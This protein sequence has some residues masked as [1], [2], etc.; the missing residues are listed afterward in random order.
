MTLYAR[1]EEVAVRDFEMLRLIS[2][3]SLH[4]IVDKVEKRIIDIEGL[5]AKEG[6]IYQT[7]L[8]EVAH[9]ISKGLLLQQQ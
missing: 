9:L 7:M 3:D 6:L 5:D 8:E 4:H 2:K 1:I